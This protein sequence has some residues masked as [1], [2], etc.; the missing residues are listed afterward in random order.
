MSVQLRW[1]LRRKLVNTSFIWQFFDSPQRTN[2]GE[3]GRTESFLEDGCRTVVHGFTGRMGLLTST[4]LSL[5]ELTLG[6]VLAS[7]RMKGTRQVAEFA[8]TPAYT[9]STLN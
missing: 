5:L 7:L 4:S 9:A 6:K 1:S 2:T 3:L 8:L